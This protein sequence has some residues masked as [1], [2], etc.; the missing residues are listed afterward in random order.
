M[1]LPLAV[2]HLDALKRQFAEKD[3]AEGIAIQLEEGLEE[4]EELRK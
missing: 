1:A 4:M 3:D 2:Q